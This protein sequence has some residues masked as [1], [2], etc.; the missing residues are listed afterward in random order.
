ML[1]KVI[2]ISSVPEYNDQAQKRGV[3]KVILKDYQFLDDFA[4]QVV[5]QIEDI[6]RKMPLMDDN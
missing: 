1:E 3:T 2:S 6:V 4:D 5:K